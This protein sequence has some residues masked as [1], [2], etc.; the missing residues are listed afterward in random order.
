MI[1]QIKSGLKIVAGFTIYMG[2]SLIF[3]AYRGGQMFYSVAQTEG[4][5]IGVVCAIALFESP[6]FEIMKNY[7]FLKENKN[8]SRLSSLTVDQYSDDSLSG[9][10]DKE[11][12]KGGDTI[13]EQQR[14]LILP[15]LEKAIRESTKNNLRIV[16]IG[17]GNGDVVAYLAKNFP[18][19]TFI[20]V[21]FSIRNAKEKYCDVNNLVFIKGYAL[22]LLDNKKLVGD[23]IFSSST[24]C[25]FTPIE[26]ENYFSLLRKNSFRE[27]ILNEPS[28]AGY[29][30][31]NN[32]EI[33]S[34]HL[35]G[36]VWFHNY[37][38]YLLKEGY[39]IKEF[40]FSHYNHP[41]SQRPDINI[42]LVHGEI[43]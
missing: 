26:L 30:Q 35:E 16:E 15:I 23:I 11:F 37:C 25:V 14:G 1:Q 41:I 36:A 29:K 7:A 9:Y 27:I 33:I 20:G 21:D 10:G 40:T 24:F 18:E 43:V 39:N 5:S 42:C 2:Y 3:G 13:L 28:W 8:N 19:H 4:K 6:L 38:G 12:T 32:N 22:D 17:T 31:K 34:K